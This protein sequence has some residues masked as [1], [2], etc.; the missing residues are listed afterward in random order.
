[1]TTMYV[2]TTL[3]QEYGGRVDTNLVGVFTEK[4]LAAAALDKAFHKA[5]DT[6]GV[7]ELNLYSH[8]TYGDTFRLCD[9]EEETWYYRGGIEVRITDVVD[10]PREEHF[11]QV[12]SIAELIKKLEDADEPIEVA[13]KLNYGVFTR[14]SISMFYNENTERIFEVD[15]YNSGKTE[16]F[17][18]DGL[19]DGW[20]T[21]IGKALQAG[22]LYYVLD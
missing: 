17:T 22:E 7:E 4:G 8:Y 2:V 3:Y 19:F 12:Q 13:L 14:K 21:L 16:E 10:I 11:E 9:G 15:D 20:K 18:L 6:M 5:C 1:M